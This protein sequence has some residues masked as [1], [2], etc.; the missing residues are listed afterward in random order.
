MFILFI[1]LLWRFCRHPRDS[2][3]R[4]PSQS[5]DS[6]IAPQPIDMARNGLGNDGLGPASFLSLVDVGGLAE[7]VAKTGFLFG[8]DGDGGKQAAGVGAARS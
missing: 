1:L 8:H 2:G 5:T 7:A 3:A 6:E 4:P